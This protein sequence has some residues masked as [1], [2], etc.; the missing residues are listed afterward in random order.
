MRRMPSR[1]EAR[2]PRSR[3]ADAPLLE[4]FPGEV[5]RLLQLG[6]IAYEQLRRIYVLGRKARGAPIKSGW[7]RFDAEDLASAE[8]IV[9]LGGGRKRLVDGRRLVLSDVAEACAKLREMGFS[10]PLLEVPLARQGRTIMALVGSHVYAPTTDQLAFAFVGADVGRAVAQRQSDDREIRRAE[11]MIRSQRDRRR[12][13]ARA[14]MAVLEAR[15]Q[16]LVA[17]S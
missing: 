1:R 7:A 14:P 15:V 5:V 12:S 11:R 9:E 2:E 4:Y 8:V 17:A 10:N 16:E 6:D 3:T 13:A